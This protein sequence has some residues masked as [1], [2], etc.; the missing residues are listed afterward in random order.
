VSGTLGTPVT[1]ATG[2]GSG[3]GA[4]SYI[5]AN[6]TAAGCTIT[7]GSL[8][9]SSS[10]TCSVVASKAA[11]STYFAVSSTPTTVTLAGLP[12]V[13]LLTPRA[14]LSKSAKVLPIKISCSGTPCSGTLTVSAVVKVKV[15]HGASTV[16][17]SENLTFGSVGYH[18]S[19]STSKS[20][21]IHLSAASRKYLA[22][23]PL[24]PTIS[25]S[26]SITDNLGKKHTLGRV[27]LLK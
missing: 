5:T 10:G 19:A 26:V 8:T 16:T 11:D 18:L 14:A 9:A 4:L 21:T 7:G 24:R 22:A 12:V 1:L 6:G 2:G 25:G 23:N 15:K 27:S 20:V 17:K 13:K 3:T